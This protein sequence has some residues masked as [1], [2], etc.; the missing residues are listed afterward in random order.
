MLRLVQPSITQ[1]TDKKTMLEFCI[2]MFWELLFTSRRYWD[3]ILY[4]HSRFYPIAIR[5]SRSHEKS[6]TSRL[7]YILLWPGLFT[8][9]WRASSENEFLLVTRFELRTSIT[10]LSTSFET[11]RPFLRVIVREKISF[12][13]SC[14]L[15]LM[16]QTLY[17]KWP[18][19]F[20]RRRC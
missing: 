5:R 9:Y 13:V 1:K 18:K 20:S 11:V 4:L 15:P 16:S 10:I 6:P 12:V 3:S 19:L 17:W 8:K 14:L 7:S 2:P